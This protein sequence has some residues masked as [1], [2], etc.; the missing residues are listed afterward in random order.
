[1][2]EYFVS[3]GELIVTEV[4]NW[5]VIVMGMGVVFIGLICLVYLFKIMSAC[6]RAAEGRGKKTENAPVQLAE[7]SADPAP[8]ADR[9]E[10]VAVI[11]A[12]LAEELGRDVAGLRIVSLRR[13][14]AAGR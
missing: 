2:G 12:A 4:P 14:G 13:I 9:G 3:K 11:A 5:L 10:L 6:I 7:G 1:M 8:I